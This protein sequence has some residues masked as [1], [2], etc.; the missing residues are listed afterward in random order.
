M[1]VSYDAGP[2]AETITYR[3]WSDFGMAKIISNY[4]D[5]FPMVDSLVQEYTSRI[6]SIGSGYQYS[7][8]DLRRSAMSGAQLDQRR[9]RACRRMMEN[10]L[11]D[12]AAFGDT[13]A[14]MTGFLNNANVPLV[15]DLDWNWDAAATTGLAMVNQLNAAITT[16]VTLTKETIVP[17][18][19]AL[20]LASYNR[21]ATR[22]CSTTGDTTN[23]ALGFFLQTSPYIKNVVSW[24]KLALA[25]A[26]GTAPRVVIYKNDP[27]ILTL[28]IPQEFEQMDPQSKNMSFTIDCHARCGGVIVYYPMGMYY[29]DDINTNP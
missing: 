2:A 6:H 19:V 26:N 12:L 15:S 27:E 4:A 16:M 14:G 11:E 13:D 9:A 21:F 8:M 18:T 10:K 28:E 24:D 20:D 3:Q 17:D 1:P 25:D 5:D 7:V 23:T 29:I 22:L